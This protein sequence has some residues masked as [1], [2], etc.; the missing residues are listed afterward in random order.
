M[1]RLVSQAEL[2]MKCVRISQI[3]QARGGRVLHSLSR[4][5]R[6]FHFRTSGARQIPVIRDRASQ[7]AKTT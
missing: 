5:H 6:H 3:K 4:V 2:I 7:N 1:D